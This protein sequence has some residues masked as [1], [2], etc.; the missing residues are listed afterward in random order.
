[1][2][3]VE[4]APAIHVQDG[5]EADPGDVEEELG[6]LPRPVLVAQREDLLP[7]RGPGQLAQAGAGEVDKVPGARYDR[8]FF[9]LS[10]IQTEYI[11]KW[12][13]TCP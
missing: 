8:P 4:V 10:V 13:L 11:Q 7:G 12:T 5:V 3:E 1:M 9:E 6:R 2:A